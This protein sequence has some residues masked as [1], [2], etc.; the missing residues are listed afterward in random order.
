MI[1]KIIFKIVLTFFIFFNSSL[2]AADDIAG[3]SSISAAAGSSAQAAAD[4]LATDAG[5]EAARTNMLTG[6]TNKLGPLGKMIK[7]IDSQKPVVLLVFDESELQQLP[8]TIPKEIIDT[9]L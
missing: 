5:K 3:M 1:R 7:E 8:Q 2:Y 6:L 9:L 4:Q